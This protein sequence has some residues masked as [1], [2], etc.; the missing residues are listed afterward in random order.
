MIGKVMNQ[1]LEF[2]KKIE[3]IRELATLQGGVLSKEQVEASFGEIG[4]SPEQLSPVYDYL[5]TKKIGI[6]EAVNPDDYLSTDEVDYLVMYKESLS[7]LPVLT[8]GEKQALYMAAMAGEE[9]AKK[10]LIENMLMDVVDMAKLYTGQGV[11]IED[12]IG[13]GNVALSMGVEMLGALEEPAE[14]PGMLAKMAMD[15][16]EELINE[17]ADNKKVDDKLVDKVNKIAD[18]A[19]ELAGDLGRKVTVDELAAE[20]KFSKKAIEDA[21]RLSGKKIEDISNE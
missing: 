16:M 1:E 21:V 15:A 5:K 19:K 20:G 10:S 11:L 3:E 12:L 6:G 9:Q 8:E 17:E 18:A 2:A 4:M 14:V 7:E 13:E